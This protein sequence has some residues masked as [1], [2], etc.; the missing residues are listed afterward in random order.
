MLRLKSPGH[1]RLSQSPLEHGI[2]GEFNLSTRA[3]IERLAG[4]EGL[5]RINR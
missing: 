5:G 1:E 2:P 3:E 4:G